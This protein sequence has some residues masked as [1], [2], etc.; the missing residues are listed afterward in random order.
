MSNPLIFE[1]C[2]SILGDKIDIN[3]YESYFKSG[4]KIA[5]LINSFT[6]EKKALRLKHLNPTLAFHFNE[7]WS[8][9]CTYIKLIEI[10]GNFSKDDL[11]K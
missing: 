9:I 7:N 8:F 3:N 4:V 2:S 11:K 10:E 5:E 1:W 6:T